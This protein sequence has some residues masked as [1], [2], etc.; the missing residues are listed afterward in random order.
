MISCFARFQ[1]DEG[2]RKVVGPRAEGI[3]YLRY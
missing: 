1:P 2:R 3:I